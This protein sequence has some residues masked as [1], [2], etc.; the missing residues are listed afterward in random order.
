MS[1]VS[2]QTGDTVP[3]GNSSTASMSAVIPNEN[4]ISKLTSFVRKA[5]LSSKKCTESVSKL[6][7]LS[8]IQN[9]NG[10]TRPPYSYIA[11]I[12]MAIESTPDKR[13]TLREIYQFIENNFPFYQ[14]MKRQAWQNGVRHNLSLNT[15]FTKIVRGGLLDNSP[16]KGS[17]WTITPN[18]NTHFEKGEFRRR[19][20]ICSD[21]RHVPPCMDVDVAVDRLKPKYRK[22][23]KE[24]LAKIKCEE[25]SKVINTQAEPSSP[26]HSMI[27]ENTSHQTLPHPQCP[28]LMIDRDPCQWSVQE[29]AS[30]FKSL[31][32]DFA[33]KDLSVDDCASDPMVHGDETPNLQPLNILKPNQQND[34][35]TSPTCHQSLK[36]LSFSIDNL[37]NN[38]HQKTTTINI[39]NVSSTHENHNYR[40]INLVNVSFKQSD[41]LVKQGVDDSNLHLF[42]PTLNNISI[43]PECS[44]LSLP[45]DPTS[46]RPPSSSY[47]SGGPYSRPMS[48]LASTAG[49]QVN[50]D[51]LMKISTTRNT[52]LKSQYKIDP[53][54]PASFMFSS[55]IRSQEYNGTRNC[56]W[57]SRSND[58]LLSSSYQSNQMNCNL[59]PYFEKHHSIINI[60]K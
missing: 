14:K 16:V 11:L 47:R 52:H 60:Q 23:V 36:S 8:Q 17:Y 25:W 27:E 20:R 7:T 43:Q 39:N 29:D 41:L 2:D 44:F 13:M 40:N 5:R 55:R 28:P 19:K 37:I 58:L 12:L 38:N 6:P 49:Y 26:K 56:C 30:M 31:H 10:C 1:S 48:F 32:I 45:Q 21:I 3:D 18:S 9:Q 51:D 22:A 15:C 34:G 50:S 24:T 54:Y 53:S 42:L 33:S 4:S 57:E 46:C 59:D 35:M